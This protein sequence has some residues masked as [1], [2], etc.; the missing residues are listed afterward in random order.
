MAIDY[1]TTE[2]IN[3]IKRRITVPTSQNFFLPD[4][5]VAYANDEMHSTVVPA[6]TSVQEEYFVTHSDVVVD[7]TVDE[8]RIPSR[9]VGGMLRDIVMIDA[10]GNELAVE[11]LQP[12]IVKDEGFLGNLRLTG[13]VVRDDKVKLVPNASNYNGR[14]IRFK[15]IRRP[16]NLVVTSKAGRITMINTLTNEVTLST[17]PTFF[18]TSL[19][20]DVINGNP[21]FSSIG[22][23]NAI[24]NIAGTTLT[25]ST[26]PTD[27]ATGQWV[28][29]SG[30]TPVPQLPYEAHHVLAQFTAA[31]ML[32]ATG[33]KKNSE[34]IFAVAKEM[35]ES[36][37][38]VLTPRIEGSPKKI[39]NR[40]G[41]FAYT[42]RSGYAGWQ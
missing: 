37:R 15:F 24:T 30:F 13:I 18:T 20:Y 5:I 40:N 26:L 4:N 17:L 1:T 25:F 27:I 23:D 32:E 42:G 19:T 34:I 8:Y 3:S 33:D 11:R 22:D 36:L 10:N 41:I 31:R 39:N 35:L 6:I 29:E 21:I 2:L 7:P 38:K 28:A 12:E 9:A 14:T 16:N